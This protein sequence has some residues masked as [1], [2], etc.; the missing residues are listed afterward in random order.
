MALER[1]FPRV[2][3]EVHIEV[4][5]LGEGM[6]AKLAY[7]WTFVSVLGFD[8]HLK[9]APARGSVTALLA[10]KQLLPAMLKRFMQPKFCPCE[11]TLPAGGASVGFWLSVHFD[12]VALQMLL[13]HEL[14]RTGRTLIR[15]ISGVGHH[16]KPQ[17]HPSFKYLVTRRAAKHLFGSAHTVPG[18]MFQ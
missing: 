7:K 8:V 5:F 18:F 16:M 15:H 12:H 1:L 14:L 2:S 11:E 10:H 9:A 13:L 4:G 3:L 6:V 17:L